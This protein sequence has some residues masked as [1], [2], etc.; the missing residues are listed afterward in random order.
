M[1]IEVC[2]EKGLKEGLELPSRKVY[3]EVK[4]FARENNLEY[5]ADVNTKYKIVDIKVRPVAIQLPVDSDKKFQL[6]TEE[7]TLQNARNIE[8]KFIE[9][10]LQQLKIR[11]GEF[12][13][14][15]KETRFRAMLSHHE[16]AFSFT[17][18]KIGCVDL[19]VVSPMVVFTILHEPWNLKL[20]IVPRALLPK[21]IKL[22]KEK[23]KVGTLELSIGPYYSR[24]FMVK[25]KLEALKFIQNMQ[26]V[27]QVTIRNM[28]LGPIVDEVAKAF[29]GCSIYS[30]F[31]I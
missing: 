18:A 26:L 16:K 15:Q 20:I 21:L 31:G 17:S 10:T 2:E 29:A 23:V 13:S 25:K 30:I 27:N 1:L 28:G 5:I 6:A 3:T 11:S 8:H 9:A 19:T 4:K 7:L 12:L 24:W 22:L 14:T